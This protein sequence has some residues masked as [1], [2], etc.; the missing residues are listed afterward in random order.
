MALIEADVHESAGKEFGTLF[1]PDA[2]VSAKWNGDEGILRLSLSNGDQLVFAGDD[3]ARI[4]RH[5][6]IRSKDKE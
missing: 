5:L 6:R 3:A 4:W 2:I 1:D